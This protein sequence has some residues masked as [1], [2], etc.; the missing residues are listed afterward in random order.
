MNIDP[1][2]ALTQLVEAPPLEEEDRARI[3]GAIRAYIDS[4]EADVQ[5]WKKAARPGIDEQARPN[6]LPAPRARSRHMREAEIWYRGT[7][8]SIRL[9]TED[10]PWGE[11]LLAARRTPGAL[12]IRPRVEGEAD[13]ILDALMVKRFAIKA[14]VGLEPSEDDEMRDGDLLVE[15]VIARNVGGHDPY[16]RTPVVTFGMRG[17][18]VRASRP[19][20]IVRGIDPT[21]P[22]LTVTSVGVAEM[23]QPPAGPDCPHD[24]VVSA[25][26][27]QVRCTDCGVFLVA[28]SPSMKPP[29]GFVEVQLFD[30]SFT[31]VEALKKKL[32]QIPGAGLVR[33]I[34]RFLISDD[35][36]A[37][38]MCRAK[39]L[40]KEIKT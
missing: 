36:A 37:I 20:N 31:A 32:A 4:L 15:S 19:Q 28:Q 33:E 2:E 11:E 21:A 3:V 9:P 14:Y 40:F 22:L 18:I 30:E 34:D 24:N 13:K 16:G 26:P 38:E 12:R 8:L 23:Q 29:L 39:Q 17:Q 27:G 25:L 5:L 10:M 1:K 35:Q 7:S 6:P